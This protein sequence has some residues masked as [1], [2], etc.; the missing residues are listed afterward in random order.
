MIAERAKVEEKISALELKIS[1]LEIAR[2]KKGI[3]EA[4]WMRISQE[5]SD[6]RNHIIPLEQRLNQQKAAAG[7]VHD[8]LRLI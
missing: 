4:M 5:I 8:H 1:D 3:S 6:L 2:G 7:I